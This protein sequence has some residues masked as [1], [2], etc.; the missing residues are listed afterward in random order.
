METSWLQDFL[1]LAECGNFSRAAERR[2]MTQPALSRRIRSLE[3]WVGAALVDRSS[4]QAILTAAGERFRPVADEVLRRLHLGQEEA[5]EAAQATASTLRFAS[6]HVLSLTFFPTWLRGLE[7]RTAIGTVSLVAD[8]MQA[9]EQVM[10]QGEA[11]F[12][13][14]HHHPAAATRLDSHAFVS[15][16]I[17][18]D[19][20]VPV[21][22]PGI[23]EA[24]LHALPGSP[25]RPAAFL[26]YS[27][28]SGM[29]R[30]LAAARA[31][32]APPAW[33]EPVFTSHVATV[34]KTM[35]RN[36]RG[37]AWSPLSVIEDDLQEGTLVRAGGEEWDIPIDIRLFRPRSR[38]SRSAEMFW[39]LA[40]APATAP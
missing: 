23:D 15:V 30:I 9:C 12:L 19:R 39:A 34:L 40:A 16:T 1:T 11:N 14:C 35:A 22:S 27:I 37:L 6:T 28:A 17:G 2:H 36:G 29:G 5:L 31:Q 25:E 13:L 26:A 33:L 4:H 20:L 38:Q 8:H 3:D 18:T 7:A 10:L 32:D 24:P 21:S